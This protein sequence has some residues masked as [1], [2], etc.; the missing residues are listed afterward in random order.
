[1]DSDRV[2]DIVQVAMNKMGNKLREDE[3]HALI[4]DA[5]VDG[6]GTIDYEEFVAATVNLNKLEKEEHCMQVNPQLNPAVV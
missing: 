3:L 5:D 6:N 4:A 1:M 2:S